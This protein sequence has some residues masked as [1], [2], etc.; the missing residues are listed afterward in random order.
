[1]DLVCRCPV[2]NVNI[3][4]N[5]TLSPNIVVR[6]QVDGLLHLKAQ[7]AEMVEVRLPGAVLLRCR[8]C[9]L[10]AGLEAQAR[11]DCTEAS[12]EPTLRLPFA[13]LTGQSAHMYMHTCAAQM[14][15][16]QPAGWLCTLTEV[17]SHMPCCRTPAARRPHRLLLRGTCRHARL[18]QQM[19]MAL[20]VSS[21]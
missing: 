4:D 7:L 10:S 1:M 11:A 6:R 15:E 19:C 13:P 20:M 14:V 16:V 5:L 12:L 2:T 9:L 21:R 8:D 17:Q 3:G 18:L